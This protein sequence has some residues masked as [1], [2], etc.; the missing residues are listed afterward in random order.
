MA[1]VGKVIP[2]LPVSLVATAVLRLEAKPWSELDLKAE[3]HRLIAGLAVGG[4]HI[5]IPR[6]DHDYAVTVGL[7]MLTLR[8]IVEREDGLY[9]ANP[10][11]V[12][13]LQYYANSIRHLFPASSS[14]PEA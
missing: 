1:A 14:M 10:G 7:R 8:H 9:R 13:L 6:R 12:P 5:Y 3:V 11:E 4:A 2:V